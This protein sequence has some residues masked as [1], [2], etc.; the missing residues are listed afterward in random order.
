M[1][2]TLVRV[3]ACATFPPPVSTAQVMG[4]LDTLWAVAVWTRTDNGAASA[5]PAMPV[6]LFPEERERV[7]PAVRVACS[8]D[9]RR[10]AAHVGGNRMAVSQL[11]PERPVGEREPGGVGLGRG[12]GDRAT[13]ARDLPGNILRG[14]QIV[15]G[16]P[17]LDLDLRSEGP[18]RHRPV[19][20]LPWTMVA[21]A[22]GAACTV[23][24]KLSGEFVNEPE[25]AVTVFAAPTA[26]PTV[27]KVLA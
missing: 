10:R 24:L 19:W 27:Q 16:V 1:P 26:V 15:E 14:R 22:A 23:A 4:T 8:R 17:E 7:L 3:E 2:L 13:P 6:W 18:N 25:V 21:I 5:C 12:G 9:N 20:S 11:I